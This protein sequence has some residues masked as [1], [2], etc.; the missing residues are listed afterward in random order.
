MPH[1]LNAPIFGKSGIPFGRLGDVA[2]KIDQTIIDS[3]AFKENGPGL[4]AQF[5]LYKFKNKQELEQELQ[6]DQTRCPK[7]MGGGTRGMGK[8]KQNWKP[9]ILYLNMGE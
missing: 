7:N 9:A 3:V 4:F 5:N 6:K 8:A 2:R 1:Q